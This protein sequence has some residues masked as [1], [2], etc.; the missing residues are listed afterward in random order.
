MKK[1]G[2]KNAGLN[3]TIEAYAC[4]CGTVCSCGVSCGCGILGFLV[5]SSTHDSVV[6]VSESNYFSDQ[7]ANNYRK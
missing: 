1:L 7:K 5:S 6:N 4:A 2:K 3:S